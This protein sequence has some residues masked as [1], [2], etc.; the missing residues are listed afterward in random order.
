L[1]AGAKPRRVG[2]RLLHLRLLILMLQKV[3]RLSWV[4]LRL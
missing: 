1:P 3:E 4:G 2:E